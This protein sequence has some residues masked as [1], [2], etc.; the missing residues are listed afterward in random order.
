MSYQLA[1]HLDQVVSEAEEFDDLD[2]SKL[3][4]YYHWSIWYDDRLAAVIDWSPSSQYIL[5][6]APSDDKFYVL[7]SKIIPAIK[8]AIAYNLMFNQHGFC[9]VYPGILD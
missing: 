7:H 5:H 4:G 6:N 2:F 8:I 9:R 3:H 1:L